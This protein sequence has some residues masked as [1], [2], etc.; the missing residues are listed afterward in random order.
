MYDSRDETSRTLAA[1]QRLEVEL[2]SY[3]E[4]LLSEELNVLL[5]REQ[6][7][8]GEMEELNSRLNERNVHLSRERGRYEL[9]LADLEE[10]TSE[11]QELD[12][13]IKDNE[14]EL[15]KLDKRVEEKKRFAYI[16]IY[17]YKSI[18]YGKDPV[19]SRM[20]IMLIISASVGNV[21]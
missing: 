20:Y 4:V 14:S 13:T 3:D 18:G 1:I 21:S 17:G 8:V 15:E 6:E 19:L 11:N 2:E 12:L 5:R 9:L 16:Y 7:M 10:V